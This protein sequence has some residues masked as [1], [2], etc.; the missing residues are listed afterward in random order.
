MASGVCHICKGPT[1]G[2][3][4]KRIHYCLACTSV[5]SSMQKRAIN[6][7]SY[8]V[9][10]GALP[11]LRKNEIACVDCGKRATDYDHRDYSKP[12]DVAPVCRKCNDTRGPA[13]AGIYAQAPASKPE[14]A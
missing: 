12:L 3:V 13:L 10:T 2:R 8:A 4:S 5:V 11:S 6:R 14:A 7:V 1:D 9:K